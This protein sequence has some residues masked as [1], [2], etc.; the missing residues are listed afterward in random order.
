[1]KKY[2]LTKKFYAT[3]ALVLLMGTNLQAQ[4]TEDTTVR[5]LNRLI[6]SNNVND[7]SLLEYKLK[8]LAASDKETDMMLAANIYSRIKKT[9]ISDS[10]QKAEL[11]KFPLGIAARNKAERAVYDAKDP[12]T[13]EKLY[14]EWVAKFP[15][16]RFPDVNH[17][18]IVYDYARSH[19]A[20]LFAEQKNAPKAEQYINM[21]KE[22]FW[23]GN[24]YAGLSAAFY[25]NGDLRHA[26]I[27]AKKAMENA[28]SFLNATDGPGRFSASGYSGLCATYINILYEEKKYDE[29]LK[30]VE[31]LYKFNKTTDVRTNY[32]Y[33]KLLMHTGHAREAYDKLDEAM[34]TGRASTEMDST[35]KALYP[36]VKGSYA[37]YDEY[38]TVVKKTARDN[39]QKELQKA[40]LKAPAPLFTLT[41]VKGKKVS[42][43]Q[44]KGKV[45]ILDFWAT[46]CGPCKRSF[47][48]MQMAQNKY[49]NDPNVKF[50]FIHTWERDSNATAEAK[51]Y[52]Q[53]NHY[54]FEVLMDLKDS[55]TKEN[56]VVS[57]YGVSGI[58]AKFIIDPQG[59][60]RFHLTGFDGNN[61]E[62]VNEISMMIEMAKKAG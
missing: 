30:Y 38:M 44:F 8:I 26:E 43:E 23:K 32:M 40:M 19:V 3:L 37:G 11:I 47:P 9:R 10:L 57:S 50:L 60:I 53:N 24:G 22:E 28:K 7:K 39:M 25:K 52:I 51:T 62:A 4:Q 54:N 18:H 48:A 35:F 5:Y 20:Q 17:D 6:Q 41:D 31:V 34:K 33:A 12:A 58:P 1:M 45:V 16:S 27:Y 21:L 49:K 2:S 42:L 61:E 13:A 15:P 46:W 56:K 14:N 36:K 59:V 55:L 29:A